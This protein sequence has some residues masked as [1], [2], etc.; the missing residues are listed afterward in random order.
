MVA[1]SDAATVSDVDRVDAWW[2]LAAAAIAL[3]VYLLTASRFV[4][5]GDNG[6]FATIFFEGGVAHPSG[7]PVYVL[8]LRAF[9]WLPAVSA[10][11]GASLATAVLGGAMVGVLT[12]ACRAWGARGWASAGVALSF[13]FT[14]LVWSL[15]TQAEVFALHALL[16]AA[17]LWVSAPGEAV[18]PTVRAFWL[19]ALVTLGFGNNHSIALLAPIGLTAAVLLLRSAPARAPL[20]GWAMLG[21]AMGSLPILALVWPPGAPDAWTWGQTGSWS[22]L[23][24]HLL[25]GDYGTTQ[26][27]I[28]GDETFALANLGAF[29][30][31][32]L[33]NAPL[34]IAVPAVAGVVLRFQHPI[35]APRSALWAWLAAFALTG[36]LL[37]MRFNL[38]PVGVAGAVVERFHVLPMALLVVPAAILWSRV[39][40]RLRLRHEFAGMLV[41]G[42]AYLGVVTG[43][44][45]LSEAH[46]PTVELYAQNVLQSL[47]QN[48]VLIGTGDHRL[49]GIRYVQRTQN[50]RPDVIYLDATMLLYPWYR[51][52]I[53]RRY[54][55]V[56][57]GVQDETHVL[58]PRT[59]M[60]S[61][62]A[63]G[64]PVYLTNVFAESIPRNFALVPHGAVHEVLRPGQSAPPLDAMFERT[65]R[66]M[67]AYAFEETV[68][69]PGT[70]GAL[71]F[72]DYALVWRRLA[73]AYRAAGN[74]EAASRC[75]TFAR[76]LLPA[77]PPERP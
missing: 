50:V 46:R 29:G 73:N 67:T 64:R 72:D 39:G 2:P 60:A 32:L 59:L 49:Y 25:R 16:A 44:E 28:Y 6:E 23:W 77:V 19:G 55:V 7:Y 15:A 1:T 20:V 40:E 52:L 34:A 26:L 56:L 71:A 3:V 30:R 27:G 4:L 63:Q 22:G 58:S 9:A 53:E 47:P 51:A 48:A 38:Q 35:A 43:H 57:D 68:P 5:G 37:L 65:R 54:E 13:G 66:T 21:A 24:H 45:R 33:T 17:I 75:E 61:L 10:A 76:R 41:V 8:W 12:Q 69:R 62:Q 74:E 31:T 36:P 70:W 18:R 42:V 14:P 11:H